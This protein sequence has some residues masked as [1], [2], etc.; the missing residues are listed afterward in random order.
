LRPEGKKSRRGRRDQEE[1]R[2]S[3]VF[4]EVLGSR[5]EQ[6]PSPKEGW[7]GTTAWGPKKAL[8]IKDQ[9][10]ATWIRKGSD[11]DKAAIWRALSSETEQK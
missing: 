7:I 1:N 4:R 2:K 8:G 11:D 10:G 5:D 3:D 9:G 6:S